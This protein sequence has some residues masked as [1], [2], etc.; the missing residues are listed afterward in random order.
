MAKRK[1]RLWRGVGEVVGA[2]PAIAAGVVAGTA[3]SANGTQKFGEAFDEVGTRWH[4]A[5]A[6]FAEEHGREVASGVALA[7][8]F[9]SHERNRYK[10]HRL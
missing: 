4:D 7:A 3:A 8:R 2:I 10:Q 1:S 9:A 5:I 6:D